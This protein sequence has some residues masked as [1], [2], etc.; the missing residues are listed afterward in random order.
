M[1]YAALRANIGVKVRRMKTKRR[2]AGLSFGLLLALLIASRSMRSTPPR[3]LDAQAAPPRPDN[4]QR[5]RHRNRHRKRLK[6]RCRHWSEGPRLYR[7]LVLRLARAR[8]T[9]LRA[10]GQ[11]ARNVEVSPPLRLSATPMSAWRSPVNT[12]EP[13]RS[14]SPRSPGPV[15]LS[16]IIYCPLALQRPAARQL[17]VVE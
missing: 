1:P 9:R 11:A 12:A 16:L 8:E 3:R 15:S 13:R 7:Q 6:P 2:A 14:A 4:R 10:N 5:S 17:N